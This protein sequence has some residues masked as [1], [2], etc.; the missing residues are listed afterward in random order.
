MNA[1]LDQYLCEKG[2]VPSR[3][4]AQAMIRAGLVTIDGTV[5]TKPA[6]TVRADAVV[7]VTGDVHPWVSRGGV[8]LDHALRHF[9]IDVTGA[10]CLDLGA[11]TGGFTEVLLARGAAKV[12]AVD[13]GRDQLHDKL[14][15]DARVASLESTHAKDLGRD[16]L[17]EAP[18]IL[19][20]DVSFISLTKVLPFVLPLLAVSARA[21]LLVKPQFESSPA[22]I[23]KGGIVRDVAIQQAAVES[24][25]TF[26]RNA[27]WQGGAAEDSPLD[28]SDGNREIFIYAYKSAS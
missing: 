24:V 20:A 8:K 3:A 18:E 17:P 2:L 23:G 21:L 27:G 13:V 7:V 22:D 16:L 5:Q 26:L 12:Y 14:R 9:G 4:R 10:I 1:R 28:G 6:A 15:G 25:L 19:V 11:S